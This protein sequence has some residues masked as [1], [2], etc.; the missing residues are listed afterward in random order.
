M[1]GNGRKVRIFGVD[2]FDSRWV[3]QKRGWLAHTFLCDARV[4]VHDAWWSQGYQHA[5][6]YDHEALPRA[7]I[8]DWLQ[9]HA[10]GAHLLHP[11]GAALFLTESAA[12]DFAAA[13]GLNTP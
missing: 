11:S 4:A 7:E 13:W 5:V 8:L 12:G 9:Q 6:L 1:S 10:P 3:V 2:T